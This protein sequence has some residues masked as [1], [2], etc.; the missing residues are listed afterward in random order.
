MDI[1]EVFVISMSIFIVV[2]LFL[3]QPHQVKGN[4]MFPTFN[5]GEYL[6]TDKITYRQRNPKKGDVVVFKAPINEDFDFIKRVLGEPGDRVKIEGGSVWVNGIKLSEPYLPP[7]Y[8]TRSGR[9]MREG[10]EILVP[11]GTWI[12]IGDNRGHSSD[13]REWGPVP[14][15][16]FVGK[17]FF[18][19]WPP[20]KM[21]WIK[22]AEYPE[23]GGN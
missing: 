18:R 5:D 17:G 10:E 9:Y 4:S 11:E 12:V 2:Y 3:M 20:N 13:S 16:N 7:E 6:M 23:L 1:I 8:T 21:G 22:S 19:Y 14:L 15:A